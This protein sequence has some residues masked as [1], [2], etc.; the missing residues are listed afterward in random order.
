MSGD[1]LQAITDALALVAYAIAFTVV[2]VVATAILV[3]VVL[4]VV[5]VV[6]LLIE[7]GEGNPIAWAVLAAAASWGAWAVLL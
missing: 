3:L 1:R 2:A 5:A 6:L 4:P 7:A